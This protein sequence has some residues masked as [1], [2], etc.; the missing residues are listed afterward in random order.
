MREEA[1]GI[2]IT[3]YLKAG[4]IPVVPDEGG[5]CE[6]VDNAALTYH[7]ND[8]A[9]E[10]LIKLMDDAVFREQQRQRCM[11]RAA[12]FSSEAYMKHQHELLK[13]IIAP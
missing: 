6:V 7:T 8:D 5:A 3:E 1:F 10:I 13:K 4:L 12:D 9:A 2:S 11:K